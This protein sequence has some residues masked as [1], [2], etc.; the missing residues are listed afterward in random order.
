[1]N[2]GTTSKLFFSRSGTLTR[3]IHQCKNNFYRRYLVFWGPLSLIFFSHLLHNDPYTETFNVIYPGLIDLGVIVL[4]AF[5]L[6]VYSNV[7]NFPHN[8]YIEVNKP[9]FQH[10][11]VSSYVN[12]F[13]ILYCCVTL[14]ASEVLMIIF[15]IIFVLC[16]V[17]FHFNLYNRAI[18]PTLF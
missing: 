18:K 15:T 1:M 13:T 10:L 9:L 5:A 7:L 16:T 2:C 17:Y 3:I 4:T 11:C 12:L 8:R 6:F 14:A